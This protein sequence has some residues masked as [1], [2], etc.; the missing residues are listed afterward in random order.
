I[1]QAITAVKT[2]KGIVVIDTSA[3]VQIAEKVRDLIIKDFGTD[4]F[5]YVFNTHG[6]FDHT[7]GNQ[8]FDEAKIIAHKNAVVEMKKFAENQEDFIQRRESF[9]QRTKNRLQGLEKESDD[10]K[11]AAW[12]VQISELILQDLKEK[13]VPRY[14]D[15]SFDDTYTLDM[16]DTT[17]NAYYFGNAHTD[18]DIFI[19][20]P[21]KQILFV[22][23]LFSNNFYPFSYYPAFK[24]FPI[25]KQIALL[26]SFLKKDP[27]SVRVINGHGETGDYKYL[28]VRRDYLQKLYV[29]LEKA[30]A[31]GYSYDDIK[32]DFGLS[33][34]F[35]LLKETGISEGYLYR[36]H[37]QFL[38]I[39]W[40][41][42]A[43]SASNHLEE[44]IDTKGL[45]E[46]EKEYKQI[47]EDKTNKYFYDEGEFNQ[48]GYNY[49]GEGKSK[50]AV[51]IFGINTVKFPNSWNTWD[52]YGEALKAAGEQE[53]SIAAYKKAYELYPSP[54]S[55]HNAL[56]E[57]APGWIKDY[58]LEISKVDDGIYKFIFPFRYKTNTIALIDNGSMLIIDPGLGGTEELLKN[59]VNSLGVTKN[60]YIINT[61]DHFDHIG[62]NG[63]NEKAK[64]IDFEN[65]EKLTEEGILEK[66]TVDGSFP[67]VGLYKFKYNNEDI[68][69]IPVEF[70]HENTNMLIYLPGR[71]IVLMGDLLLSQSFPAV[72][73]RAY[74]YMKFLDEV[75]KYF[76]MDCKFFPGHGRILDYNELTA[77]RDMLVKTSSLIEKAAEAGKTPFEMRRD[78]LLKEYNEYDNMLD[79]LGTNYWI[80]NIYNIYY[81]KTH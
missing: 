75:L 74:K 62:A 25:K 18:S 22:G 16:G 59:A 51:F 60:E 11:Q 56:N 35:D 15:I 2:E 76:S 80:K 57:A 58:K 64:L 3:T 39:F 21:E 65:L 79:W 72:G 5:A 52:S 66:I 48:S 43:V 8:V 23:D 9:I 77:Y 1:S 14:P 67:F 54:Q 50:E 46:A 30:Y 41:L 17:F 31:A 69:F 27:E 71:K 19:F 40:D 34:K 13:F 78:G 53:K 42:F 26:D 61:H 49:L 28:Q 55:I 36:C 63:F 81:Q 70:L 6:H 20:I 7:I 10:Y 24:S 44:I 29:E 47:S 37:D 73:D 33:P 45:A 4:N 12:L 38:L 32:Q 68:F